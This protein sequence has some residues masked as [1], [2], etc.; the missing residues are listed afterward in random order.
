MKYVSIL[1]TYSK[2]LISKIN[3]LYQGNQVEL[4]KG[5]GIYYL[6][7]GWPKS[8][9]DVYPAPVPP[10]V[11]AAACYLWT[12]PIYLLSDYTIYEY[13]VNRTPPD[14]APTYTRKFSEINVS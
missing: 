5:Y 9:S 3:L 14:F 10:Y 7:P 8:L 2:T 11:T 1:V 6:Q 4:H 12:S 13:A